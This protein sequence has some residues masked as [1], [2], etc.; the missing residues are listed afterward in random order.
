MAAQ[1][2]CKLHKPKI[3]RLKAGYLAM[4]NLIYQSWLKDIK[5]HVEDWY[6]T[7]GEAIQLVKDF[8]AERALDEV[9]IYMGMIVDDQQTFDGIVNHLKSTFQSGETISEL[10]SNFYCYHQR[11][12]ELEDVFSNDLQIL[13][14]KIIACK[15]SFRAEVSEQLK[16]QYAHKLHDQYYATIAQSA[17]Q[18]SD[19]ME[20]FTQFWGHLALTFSSHSK[21][22]KISSQATSIETSSSLISE[23]SWQPSLS[24]KTPDSNK[25]E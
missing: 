24:K 12:N 14:R 20:N 3:N 22:G 21:L 15:P 6:L 2:F 11:E 16:H 19:H 5:L 25:V 4:T 1:E 9:E 17:L 10:I 7:E 23:E 13:V 8:I 18:I